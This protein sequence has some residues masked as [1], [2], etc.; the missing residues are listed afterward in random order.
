[1]TGAILRDVREHLSTCRECRNEEAVYRSM[2][3]ATKQVSENHLS[4]DFNTRL[5]DRLAQERF[6]ETRSKAYLPKPAP[7]L[8]WRRL[9]PAVVSVVAIALVAVSFSQFSGSPIAQGP[10]AAVSVGEN[11]DYLT[12][13]PLRDRNETAQLKPEWSLNGHMAQ[14]DR[15][16]RLTSSMTQRSG[17]DNSAES[18][19]FQP[20]A[21]LR[22]GH[23]PF[24]LYFYR[25][26]PVIKTYDQTG[27]DASYKESDRVY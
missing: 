5:M 22:P 27:T 16:S 6:A 20:I 21:I 9:V 7:L 17:F 13:Q 10:V 11:D 2:R 19:G 8:Q 25:V 15:L 18:G 12:A 4:R 26:K 1:L 24:V 23:Q 14:T 3:L